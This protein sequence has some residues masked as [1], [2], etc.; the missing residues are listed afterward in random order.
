MYAFI[1][2]YVIHG[3]FAAL[4]LQILEYHR[5]IL[6]LVLLFKIVNNLCA[7]AMS[8]VDIT[9]V[10]TPYCGTEVLVGL[11]EFLLLVCHCMLL[12]RELANSGMF[13]LGMYFACL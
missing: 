8:D 10:L 6:D 7:V 12:R 3:A 2:K 1:T 4:G 9:R 5:L 13:C 11:Y